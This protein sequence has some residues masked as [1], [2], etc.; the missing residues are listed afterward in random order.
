MIITIGQFLSSL[1]IFIILFQSLH[2]AFPVSKSID[3]NISL[4]F[5]FIVMETTYHIFLKKQII[6]E[7]TFPDRIDY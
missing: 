5:S 1:L 7:R 4:I 3:S 6:F 2:L